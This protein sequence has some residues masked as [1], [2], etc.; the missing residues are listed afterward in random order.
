MRVVTQA[1]A[2]TLLLGPGFAQQATAHWAFTPPLRNVP[3]VRDANWCRDELDR[4]VLAGLERDGLRPS[5][6]ADPA[7]LLRRVHLVLT[8]LPPTPE[9]VAAFVAD[10][11]DAAY[12]HVVDALLG[13]IACA[14]HM[15]T[16]WLDLARFADTYGYQADFDC[17]TW[18]WRDW[19]LDSLH[20]DKPWDRFVMELVAGD[21]LLDASD[22]S[23]IATAFWRLHRQTNEGG[24]IDEE[25]RQE[26]IADRT[27]TFGAVFLG[28]TVGCAR[29]HDHK[30]DPT[31]MRDYYALGSFFV[32]DEAGLYPYSTGGTPQPALRLA[33]PAQ[34][35]KSAE[36]QAAVAAAQEKVSRHD[37]HWQRGAEPQTSPPVA[38]RS[39]DAPGHLCDGDTRLPIPNLPAFT[40]DDSFS[41]RLVVTCPDKK[42][43]AV[44]LHTSHY[45]QDADTQG[46]QLLLKDGRVCWE[47]VHHWPG[48][49]AAV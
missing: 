43:R 45:T 29:C 26:Y 20:A 21:C 35:Q 37:P 34:Q 18:P 48:S 22:T 30:S 36:L 8:G 9:Q 33:T 24:S 49:A 12:D 16:P 10:P 2:V 17:R 6:P 7:V 5:A 23:R 32:I 1:W 41:V 40:R 27:D 14:E 11:S 3:A 28:L 46:Y 44:L 15:A 25:W 4:C 39:F 42:D 13:D 19:L 47:I 38:E 31:T